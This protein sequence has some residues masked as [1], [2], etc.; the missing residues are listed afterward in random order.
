[1]AARPD[2]MPPVPVDRRNRLVVQGAPDIAMFRGETVRLNVRYLDADGRPIVN[3]QVSLG[4]EDPNQNLV[5]IRARGAQT[6][7]NGAASFEITAQ[8]VDGRT[9]L[10]AEAD[11]ALPAYWVIRVSQNPSGQMTVQVTYDSQNGRYR[12]D[13][14]QHVTVKLV[15][16][17]CDNA[18]TVVPG[19]RTING[20]AIMPFDGDDLSVITGVPSGLTFAALAWG[21]NMLNRNIVRGCTDGH[22]VEGGAE[23]VVAVP[24]EDQP[25]EFKGTFN[26]EHR[27]NLLG[28][29]QGGANED[30]NDFID[31]LEIFAALGGANEEGPFPRGN[32]L[33]NLLCDRA[34]IDQVLCI[35]IRVVGAPV[36]E[37]FF[38]E[39]AMNNPDV[40]EALEILNILGDLFT[41]LSDLTVEGQM[42]FVDSYPDEEGY[43]GRA[44]MA[45]GEPRN[46]SRWQRLRFQWRQ[47]CP[48]AQP[49][50][51]ERSFDLARENM[52]RDTPIQA[53]FDARLTDS[54]ILLI[55]RHQ[56]GLNYGLFVLL[57]LEEWILPQMTGRPAPVGIEALFEQLID[58]AQLDQD[59]GVPA[60]TCQ[61]TVIPALAGLL[62]AQLVQINDGTDL[63]T[64]EGQV[65]IAD[66][67]P[68]LKVDRFYD[69]VWNGYFGEAEGRDNPEDLIP[70]IGTFEG[71]RDTECALLPGA[72]ENMNNMGAMNP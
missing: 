23:V 67:Y 58:C 37:E 48:F 34:N 24:L 72:M 64:L 31:I 71:C 9:R 1:M 7:G 13:N 20:P 18:L 38:N 70:E 44:S 36:I 11:N 41:N 16:G 14:I 10:M 46:Q 4:P 29:I 61:M 22:T 27:I 35:A 49:E 6:D 66:E 5:S 51:C 28:M 15:Q 59:L 33:I 45:D 40:A 57:A 60:G 32:A 26:I 47:G 2:M 25:L 12:N 3:G 50:Q 17:D 43:L 56:L 65:K 62:E 42:E 30:V 55:G 39:Q 68:N 63:L 19:R 8:M 54:N 69:G 21:R 52:G 53:N